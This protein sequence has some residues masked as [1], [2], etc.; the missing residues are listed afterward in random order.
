MKNDSLDGVHPNV[1]QS[2]ATKWPSIGTHQYTRAHLFIR[3]QLAHADEYVPNFGSPDVHIVIQV[4]ELEGGGNLGVAEFS[5][6]MDRHTLA[7]IDRKCGARL[8]SL[9][10]EA[11]QNERTCTARCILG[12]HKRA[13]DVSFVHVSS[14]YSQM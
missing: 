13:A 10:I 2:D 11:I 1:S 12:F 9:S 14:Y 3:D 7:I 5:R 8:V 4:Q 6:P